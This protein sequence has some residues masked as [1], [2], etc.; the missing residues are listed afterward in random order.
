[1]TEQTVNLPTGEQARPFQPPVSSIQQSPPTTNVVHKVG[2]QLPRPVSQAV[3]EGVQSAKKQIGTIAPE[4][5]QEVK[6]YSQRFRLRL[7]HLFFL[8][9]FLAIFSW[10]L[11][12][13]PLFSLELNFLLLQGQNFFF[14]VLGGFIGWNL[15][16]L[17]YFVYIYFTNPESQVSVESKY[18]LKARRFNQAIALL[19][20]K[21][22]H[23]AFR[24]V[25]F[26]LVWVGL[27]LF[28]LTSTASFLGKGLVMGLGLNLLI[29]EWQEQKTKPEV[30]NSRLFWQIKRKVSLQEQRYYL[31]IMTGVF[32]VLSLLV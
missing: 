3:R 16:L 18:L 29:N 22:S 13:F 7:R 25:L 4:V 5:K 31:W 14:W 8:G 26:R 1:M 19:K 20:T 2:Q 28:T 6:I 32:A 21:E 30:L 17:D 23:L 24:G 10:R 15:N 9:Y 11:V 27:A 12:H